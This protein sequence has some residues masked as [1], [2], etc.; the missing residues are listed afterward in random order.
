MGTRKNKGDGKNK[1]PCVIGK[2]QK[3]GSVVDKKVGLIFDFEFYLDEKCENTK[4]CERS[5]KS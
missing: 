2:G 4:K 1:K 5:S 3:V